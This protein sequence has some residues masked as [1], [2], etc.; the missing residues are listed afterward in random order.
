[1]QNDSKTN[2]V[3]EK[4]ILRHATRLHKTQINDEATQNNNK[5]T[6]NNYRHKTTT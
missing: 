1:M 3:D 4:M 6:L 2:K 5:V